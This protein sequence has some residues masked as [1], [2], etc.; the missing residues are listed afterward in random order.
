M[1]TIEQLIVSALRHGPPPVEVITDKTAAHLRVV[2]ELA[3]V[4]PHET[5]YYEKSSNRHPHMAPVTS[6]VN[7]GGSA[8]K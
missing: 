6:V 4:A 1:C 7:G 8:S 5:D 2:D 3:P